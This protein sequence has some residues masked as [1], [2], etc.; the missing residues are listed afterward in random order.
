MASP[1]R[2]DKLVAE[3]HSPGKPGTVGK[4]V[5]IVGADRESLTL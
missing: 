1:G 4:S 2:R 3:F 5:S